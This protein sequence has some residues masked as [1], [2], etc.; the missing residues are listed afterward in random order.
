MSSQ[1]TVLALSMLAG[2]VALQLHA[3]PGTAGRLAAAF[4]AF[5]APQAPAHG[6][7]GH[8]GSGPAASAAAT[9]QQMADAGILE[10]PESLAMRAAAGLPPLTGAA[11]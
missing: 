5:G 10:P 7:R 9:L 8:P 3:S 6:W 11:D 4:D 2:V 1:E